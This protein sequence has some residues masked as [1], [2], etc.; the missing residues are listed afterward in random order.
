[1][2]MNL[3]LHHVVFDITGATGIKVARA[4]DAGGAIGTCW[5]MTVMCGANRRRKRS[6]LG[7]RSPV[8][9]KQRDA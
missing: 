3:R 1:M 5:Q 2:E 7:C 9:F 6:A 8:A 4:I